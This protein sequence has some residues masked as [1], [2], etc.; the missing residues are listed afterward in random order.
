MVPPPPTINMRLCGF[1]SAMVNVDWPFVAWQL[2]REEAGYCASG[3]DGT[4]A[5]I[6]SAATRLRHGIEYLVTGS[7]ICRR[8]MLSEVDNAHG[9]SG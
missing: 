6:A 8:D 1:A 9:R 5:M 3:D 2:G 7:Q 4:P